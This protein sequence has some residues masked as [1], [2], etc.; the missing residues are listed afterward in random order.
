MLKL[1]GTPYSVCQYCQSLLLRNDAT[2][3]SVGKVA[4]V[5]DDFSP[6]QLGVQGYFEGKHFSLIGR[7]RKSWEQGS[8]NEWCALFDDQRMGWLAEAQG[9]WVMC[10]EQPPESL[11]NAPSLK[12]ID[13]IEPGQK[14]Y[15]GKQAYTVSDAKRVL[16]DAAEGELS[17]IDYKGQVLS[18]VDLRGA[19]M[20]F[21]TVEFTS[22]EINVFAGRFIDFAECRFSGLR[23]LDG[24]V[25]P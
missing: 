21:A 11:R 10:F 20:Q 18:S 22:K 1:R 3:E 9:D 15:I 19:G 16:C 7:I 4:Q 8:W 25:A 2:Y 23:Q 14:W 5:P 12:E 24:W 17:D 6:M 13:R